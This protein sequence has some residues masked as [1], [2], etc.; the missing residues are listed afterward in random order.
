MPVYRRSDS[1][2][3]DNVVGM[4]SS[5]VVSGLLDDGTGSWL[6]PEE[7]TR[8]A[9]EEA[10]YLSSSFAECEAAWRGARGLLW[11]RISNI[12]NTIRVRCAI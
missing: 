7:K 1:R 11:A 3:W 6:D 4:G 9:D 12:N 8:A 10:N 2:N 5:G